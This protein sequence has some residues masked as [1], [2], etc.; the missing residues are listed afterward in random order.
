MSCS[1][2]TCSGSRTPSVITPTSW[3]RCSDRGIEVRRTARRARPKP[4][5]TPKPGPGC[6][7][8]KII[9]N[10][11]G[12]GLVDDTRAFLDISATPRTLTDYLIGGLSTIDLPSDFRARLPYDWP[13]RPAR[14]RAST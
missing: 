8:A 1:S 9:P 12:I 6:W 13:A 7:T 14:R 5:A 4:S 3:R 2:T 10:E 11:V